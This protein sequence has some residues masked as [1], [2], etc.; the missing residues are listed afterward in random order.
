MDA[1]TNAMQVAAGQP[2]VQLGACHRRDEAGGDAGE[3]GRAC[4]WQPDEELGPMVPQRLVADGAIAPVLI[5]QK[6]GAMRLDAEQAQQCVEGDPDEAVDDWLQDAALTK[7]A[8][9]EDQVQVQ[10]HLA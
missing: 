5:L 4:A 8:G 9:I 1:T 10:E 6:I 7:T 3:W 2:T